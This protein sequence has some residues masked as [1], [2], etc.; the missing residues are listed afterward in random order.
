MGALDMLHS[1]IAILVIRVPPYGSDICV[2]NLNR[3]ISEWSILG[4]PRNAEMVENQS[5][6]LPSTTHQEKN[7]HI[8][9]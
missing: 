1:E 4:R 5:R 8:G 3:A 6:V 2:L 7:I 9:M